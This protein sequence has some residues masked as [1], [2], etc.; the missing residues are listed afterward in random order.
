MADLKFSEEITLELSL[1]NLVG[2]CQMDTRRGSENSPDTEL[3]VHRHKNVQ[4]HTSLQVG[5]SGE[6]QELKPEK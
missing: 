5:F 6:E 2:L 1:E 4:K 3:Q